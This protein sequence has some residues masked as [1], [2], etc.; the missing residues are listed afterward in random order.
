MQFRS[1]YLQVQGDKESL[2][3]RY[4]TFPQFD[5]KFSYFSSPQ[6]C[7]NLWLLAQSMVSCSLKRQLRNHSHIVNPLKCRV[8]PASTE[9][10]N[11]YTI[12]WFY[13]STINLIW[14]SQIE[15]QTSTF[16]DNGNFL[17]YSC[18]MV[19]NSDIFWHPRSCPNK[20]Q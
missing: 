2:S 19:Q 16:R 9:Y 13:K 6:I 11:D 8:E 1:F 12:R 14:K 15:R 20:S 4:C 18:K 5:P 10:M 7:R 17:L 3:C